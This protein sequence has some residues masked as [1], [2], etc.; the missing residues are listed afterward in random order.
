MEVY[1][2]KQS[3]ILFFLIFL[4]FSFTKNENQIKYWHENNKID[5]NDF[6]VTNNKLKENAFIQV[7]VS[8]SFL[9]FDSF[10]VI[11]SYSYLDRKLSFVNLNSK[12]S[13]TLLHE[14]CHFNINEFRRR[15]IRQFIKKYPF[16]NKR[17]V[18]KIKFFTT[19]DFENLDKKLDESTKKEFTILNQ[20]TNLKK[21]DS[22]LLLYD[23]FSGL[24]DTVFVNPPSSP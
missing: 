13:L 15:K 4:F 2:C 19:F 24:E 8:V 3:K 10:T 9:N 12:D 5:F 17:N 20:I 1:K 14:Q 22:L 18:A 21:I 11:T 7:G 23:Q 16:I 6:Q